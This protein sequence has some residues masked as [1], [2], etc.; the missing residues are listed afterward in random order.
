MFAKQYDVSLGC[1]PFEP[2]LISK[3]NSCNLGSETSKHPPHPPVAEVSQ[4]M[5]S[6]SMG[7]FG[8]LVKAP[9]TTPPLSHAQVA[10]I[11]EAPKVYIIALDNELDQQRLSNNNMAPETYTV[12]Q[13]VKPES[14]PSDI[15]ANF[16]RSRLSDV[17]RG[18]LMGAFSAH[19]RAW[20]KI[21]SDNPPR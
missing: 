9:P 18:G 5:S 2:L 14:V 19:V 15:E 12:I 10:A 4:A 3:W 8:P 21:V 11:M 7:V 13:G 20:Q 16:T 1:Y 6:S 17:R